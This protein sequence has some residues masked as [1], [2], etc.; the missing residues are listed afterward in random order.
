MAERSQF[1]ADLARRVA[2]LTDAQKDC[3]ELVSD[4]AT[5]K[6][7]ALQLGISRHTV[8][9]RMR[10][11]MST[12]GVSS[13]R[14]AAMLFRTSKGEPISED[15]VAAYVEPGGPM[16]NFSAAVPLK[17]WGSRNR[18]SSGARLIAVI[19]VCVL[20]IMLFGILISGIN[21]LTE[22]RR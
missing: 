3:L 10:A 12:L 22:L 14:E 7:I 2:E 8:D 16:S 19:M 11:A 21:A 4:H 1:D 17:F 13:R 20:T 5:S 6:E 9:A 18:M 15:A